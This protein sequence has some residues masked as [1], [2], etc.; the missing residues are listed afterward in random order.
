MGAPKKG[1]GSKGLGLEALLN[2]KITELNEKT[3]GTGVFEVDI[4]KVEPNKNQP[5]KRFEETALEELAESIKEH[6]VLQPIILKKIDSGYEIIA[7]ERRWRASKIAG[8]KKIPAIV[9]KIDELKAFETA[10]VENLQ[11]EGLNP[12]E[13]AKSYKRL[14][15]EF[16]LSQEEA[17]KKV[18]KSRSVVANAMRLLNL[19]ERVQNFVSENKLTNG[20]GRAL[21]G[22]TDKDVQ[23]ELAEKIIEE[24]LSVRETESLVK[25]ISENKNKKVS[26]KEESQ[27]KK[28]K[29][30]NYKYIENDLKSIFGTKVKLSNKKNKGK[31]EIEYYSDEDLDRLISLIKGIKL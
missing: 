1:L 14:I 25:K 23:F 15:E 13:E 26:E 27:S 19:D 29:T 4:D 7:G 31:I 8:M 5:R 12:M 3:V 21:L 18:G 9:K 10:L 6:G 17:G 30:D 2:N 28:F 16:S 20:H 24:E 11:R 22:I